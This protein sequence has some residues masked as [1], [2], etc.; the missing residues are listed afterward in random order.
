MPAS[1][2]T[3]W[4]AGR[5]RSSHEQSSSSGIPS[6]RIRAAPTCRQNTHAR[7]SRPRGCGRQGPA[8]LRETAPQRGLAGRC[9][10]MGADAHHPATAVRTVLAVLVKEVDAQPRAYR[11]TCA[12][13]QP[14]WT[15]QPGG[16]P[17]QDPIEL[18][19]VRRRVAVARAGGAVRSGG[20]CWRN[21]P[22]S[23]QEPTRDRLAA[24]S[25]RQAGFGAAS[26]V[27]AIV[28]ASP[29]ALMA[30]QNMSSG[31]CLHIP[32]AA[33]TLP[34]DVACAIEPRVIS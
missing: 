16:K 24:W 14:P 15:T 27:A 20:F 26:A 10:R 30:Y 13:A 25:G 19:E 29:L 5:C 33:T 18:I 11:K 32:L 6:R 23:F 34:S 12:V 7:W 31:H 4:T 1:W 9:Q 2:A 17:T 21:Q 22:A 8:V 28:S 3:R